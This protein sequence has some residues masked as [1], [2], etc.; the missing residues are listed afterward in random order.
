VKRVRYAV[1]P[2]WLPDFLLLQVISGKVFVLTNGY[3][4]IVESVT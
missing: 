3:L 1:D 2:A 4:S